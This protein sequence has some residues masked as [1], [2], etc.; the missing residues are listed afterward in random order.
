MLGL[1]DLDMETPLTCLAGTCTPAPAGAASA[2]A[3][4]W[5]AGLVL[6]LNALAFIAT[7][8]ASLL[9]CWID[10]RARTR[11]RRAATERGARPLAPVASTC[12]VVTANRLTAPYLADASF[13]VAGL[14]ALIGPS[15]AGKST[16]L[17]A[18]AGRQYGTRGSANTA[19]AGLCHVGYVPQTD[20]LLGSLST[21]ETL[22]FHATLRLPRGT[23]R[24]DRYARVYDTLAAVGLLERA[25]TRVARLSG[26]ERRRLA[27]ACELLALPLVLLLDEPTSG[28]DAA[29]ALSIVQLLSALAHEQRVTIICSIHQPRS[30]IYE[31]FGTVVLLAHS[32]VLY[33]GPRPGTLNPHCV[34]N[35][36]AAFAHAA[37]AD[38]LIDAAA[39]LDIVEARTMHAQHIARMRQTPASA[40]WLA[41]P[42]CLSSATDSTA[43]SATELDTLIVPDSAPGGAAGDAVE[44][45]SELSNPN[46]DSD[47]NNTF[48]VVRRVR[49]HTQT[50]MLLWRGTLHTLRT[51]SLAVAHIG[52]SL[53]AALLVG[54]LFRAVDDSWAGLQNRAGCFFFLVAFY[55]LGA[56][57]AT[58]TIIA[59]R[60]L[61]AHERA[62]GCYGTST[63]FVAKVVCDLLPLR[64]VPPL[65]LAAIAYPL[66]GLAP[67]NYAQA[68]FSATLV[69]VSLA[70]TSATF[71]LAAL[72][73]SIAVAN[74]AAAL[75]VLGAMLFSG[76]L[77]NGASLS[78]VYAACQRASF[79]RYGFE[80]LMA[81]QLEG[82]TTRIAVPGGTAPVP[83]A[84]AL[85]MLSLDAGRD[86]VSRNLVILVALAL[87][88]L[89]LAY[90][91][92]RWRRVTHV[93]TQ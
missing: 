60:A 77:A 54:T 63:F 69:L 23:P 86:T 61:L 35:L 40:G 90:A 8:C 82:H 91:A 1:A 6:A 58:E 41:E 80:A 15:G 4:R 38:A 87:A 79:F 65:L 24:V 5:P 14:V 11:A 74:L 34:Q 9:P 13:A 42:A 72:A 7:A 17:R 67:G 43:D 51:P 27:L 68:V 50:H 46:G 48:P 33:V 62:S 22:E 26:G 29:S 30:A 64:I 57:S 2:R 56:L 28:L 39:R 83:A 12:T 45:E 3:H 59:D 92:L 32:R 52:V 70:A 76:F 88:S 71:A 85:R 19:K 47:D 78:P 93:Y 10:M 36:R 89:V 53:A 66:V 81:S 73:P 37:D 31:L 75:H 25:D 44:C 84:L 55:A 16:L 49:W 20:M 18:L 21:F